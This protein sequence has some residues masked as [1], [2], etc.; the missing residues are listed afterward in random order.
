MV[1]RSL[2]P[3]WV[4]MV[5]F[6]SHWVVNSTRLSPEDDRLREDFY[7]EALAFSRHTIDL[8]FDEETMRPED[9]T[10]APSTMKMK[11]WYQEHH[12]VIR[13]PL[14]RT[15]RQARDPIEDDEERLAMRTGDMP[16]P[17]PER[18]ANPRIREDRAVQDFRQNSEKMHHA[19]SEDAFTKAWFDCCRSVFPQSVR[20]KQAQTLIS[21]TC[22]RVS[23]ASSSTTCVHSTERVNFEKAENVDKPISSNEK[24]HVTSDPQL[25]LLTEFW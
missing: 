5:I 9:A 24:H 13:R 15:E 23:A 22:R 19:T 18:V 25:S 16:P 1:L 2:L 3:A 11:Q 17:E 4:T 14:E 8:E 6:T 20:R 12:R 10:E 7:Y 21:I